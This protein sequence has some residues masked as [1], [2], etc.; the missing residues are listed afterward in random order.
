MLGA[1]CTA[2][3][4]PANSVAPT[5]LLGT[6]CWLIF[7]ENLSSN[8][9]VLSISPIRVYSVGVLE[10]IG[11]GVWLGGPAISVAPNIAAGCWVLDAGPQL[12]RRIRLPPT[13]LLGAGCW[14]A[15]HR[16][17]VTGWTS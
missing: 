11:R 2:A 4:V 7:S 6:V 5:L 10:D 8:F 9:K 13:L 12:G 15:R 17:H 3:G 16:L 1:G 14:V